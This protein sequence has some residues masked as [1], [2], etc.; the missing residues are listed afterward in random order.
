MVGGNG[1]NQFR[2]YAGQNAGNQAGCNDVI[3]NQVIQNVVQN[4]RV[5]NVGNQNGLIGVQGNGNQNQIENGNLVAARAKGNAAGQNGTQIRCYNC[6]GVEEYDLM[7]AAVDL[8]EIKEVN[9]NCILMANLQQASTLGTQTN[10]ALVYDTNGSAEV[11]ENCDDNEIFNMFTQNEQYT[12]LLEPILESHQVP[13]N[14]NDVISEDTSVEQGGEIVEQHPINFEETRALYES[15]YQNLAIEVEKFYSVNRK[16]KETNAN[17]TTE[18]ARYKNQESFATGKVKPKK[19]K[20]PAS[21]KLK[22]VHA[23]PKEPT[24]KGKR[25]KRAAKKATTAPTTSV[26]IRDRPD[27][28]VSKKK[29]PVRLVE[30]KALNVPDEPT[31]K[32]KD[33][34]KGTGVKPGVPDVCKDDSFDNNNDS[35]GDSEEE[36]DDVNDKDKNDDGNKEDDSDNDDDGND[37]EGNDDEGTNEDSDQT[38]SD[39]DENPSFTLKDYK[40]EEQYEEFVLNPERNKS[41]DDDKMY[42]E[43]D[44]DV[45]KEL[46]ED[47]NITQGLRYTDL[48]NAQQGP[49]QSSSIL[50]DFT[51]KLLNLD[52]PS[53]DINSLM[54]TLTIPH[55]PL[56]V[57]PSSHPTIIPQ[58]Q[59]LDSTTTITYLIMTLPESPNFTS[60]FQFDQRVSALETKNVKDSKTQKTYYSFATGK[61]GERVKRAAKKA[62]I[63]PTTG[64]V[65]RD[66]L[67]KSVSKKKAP[68]KIGKDKGIELL[69]DATLLKEAQMKKSLKKSKRQTHNLQASGSRVP[70]VSKDDSSDNNNDSWGDGEEESDDVNDKDE[71]DDDNK[72]DDSD[73]D[74]GGNDDEGTN[75]DSD[76]TDS[77]DDDNPS[78]TLKDY[79]EEERYKE[80]VL[81]PERNK[82][83]DDDKMY[84]EKD[85]DVAKELYGFMQEEEDAHVTLTT[86]HDKTKGLLQSS[87]ISFDFTS[88]LLNL[89][90]PSLDIN[91]L[92]NTL[93]I[94]PPPPLVNLSLHPT[95]IPQQQTLDS[96]TTITYPTMTLPESPNFASLFQF[97]QRVSALETKV[98]KGR[99]YPFDL[100]KPLPVI[101]DQGRQVVPAGYFINN[102]LE[103]LKGGSSS[104]KYMTSTIRTKA[105]KYNNIE[106][107]EYM[108]P[109]L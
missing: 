18:L 47:W 50:S 43:K 6:K 20:K 75:K 97:D 63:A 92:M 5:Q 34:S 38:D 7:A 17:M 37:D 22:T 107:I 98:S 14:D 108:V 86:V 51:S 28:S 73:N 30:T 3:G 78:F 91:S 81:T 4:L 106:G 45:A 13:H 101:K 100:S 42:E 56:L 68:A 59:T 67:D 64:V 27:K 48:T 109:R 2:Q 54:N 44:D 85:D 72:E 96:T 24:Q 19:F 89:D 95:T 83:D 41:D 31:G 49:L 70:D 10:S 93:T 46:Y 76:Q 29:S 53:L 104:R 71:N 90:D 65:I 60:L 52:D 103:Y 39:D 77:D 40:E 8:D 74:D 61:K 16:L 66:T 23:S 62:T 69:S 36:S 1:G 26:V 11:H 12:E 99:E 57:N 33:T 32:T 55:P 79:E 84:N 58:Q 80:F 15:L 9:A 94:P 105:D 21:P 88:K 82:S 25:V 87:S 102:D 35:W